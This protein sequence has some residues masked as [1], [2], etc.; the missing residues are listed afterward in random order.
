[1][2]P[3]VIFHQ[4]DCSKDSGVH[5]TIAVAVTSLLV[6]VLRHCTA[7]NLLRGRSPF[8][9]AMSDD[10]TKVAMREQ[11]QAHIRATQSRHSATIVV[12]LG[13]A[14]TY[15][16]PSVLCLGCIPCDTSTRRTM[17]TDLRPFVVYI[18]TSRYWLNLIASS[19]YPR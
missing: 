19:T 14:S 5:V 11:G 15:F 13:L 6:G 18:D 2:L 10:N 4:L 3:A 17:G 9:L 7:P 8:L 12:S 16:A 1:M